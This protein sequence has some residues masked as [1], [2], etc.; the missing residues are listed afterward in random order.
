M[1]DI[2]ETFL[3]TFTRKL[4]RAFED[5]ANGLSTDFPDVAE[6][7]L[8]EVG[9]GGCRGLHDYYQSRVIKY[10]DVLRKR[11]KDLSEYYEKIL[12][13]REPSPNDDINK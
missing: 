9:L 2:M 4:K 12:I 3:K 6:R 1:A 7:V 5:E 11:C 8:V 13:P 10:I